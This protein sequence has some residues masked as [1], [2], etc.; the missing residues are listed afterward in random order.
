MPSYTPGVREFQAD[1]ETPGR[2]VLE[3]DTV[4]RPDAIVLNPRI[5][6]SVGPTA[7]GDISAGLQDRTWR[8]RAD[9]DNIYLARENDAGNGWDAEI[10][11]F[12]DYPQPPT[13][14]ALVD[15]ISLCFNEAAYPIVAMERDG[16]VWYVWRHPILLFYQLTKVGAGRT[17]KVALDRFLTVVTNCDIPSWVHLIYLRDAELIRLSEQSD[18]VGEEIGTLTGNADR[19]LEAFFPTDGRRLS[20][21]YS[22]HDTGTG[23][24]ELK[25]QD[26]L[27]YPTDLLKRPTINVGVAFSIPWYQGQQFFD[28][29]GSIITDGFGTDIRIDTLDDVDGIEIESDTD[30]FTEATG[31][32]EQ[33][34]DSIVD[35]PGGFNA[36]GGVTK[37]FVLTHGMGTMSPRAFRARTYRIIDGDRCYSQWEYFIV[38]HAAQNLSVVSAGVDGVLHQETFDVSSTDGTLYCIYLEA[39]AIYPDFT[40]VLLSSPQTLLCQ[41]V[42]D[43]NNIWRTPFSFSPRNKEHFT[44]TDVDGNVFDFDLFSKEF[45]SAVG[46]AP[47]LAPG[48]IVGSNQNPWTFPAVPPGLGSDVYFPGWEDEGVSEEEDPLF[49]LPLPIVQEGSYQDGGT[50]IVSIAADPSH[51]EQ[52]FGGAEVDVEIGGAADLDSTLILLLRRTEVYGVILFDQ[53]DLPLIESPCFFVPI[54]CITVDP[55]TPTDLISAE[56]DYACAFAPVRIVPGDECIPEGILD[57]D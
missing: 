1:F 35:F 22:D 43:V 51:V 23:R 24:W 50:E 6:H 55:V 13:E 34:Y 9:D 56:V 3:I 7:L 2:V 39:G 20:I 30:D 21:V 4:H 38:G 12:A 26:T 48:A 45:T 17:P 52:I 41:Q 14:L 18:F 46:S 11:L 28:P 33:V 16:E 31:W 19:Y 37:G 40:E 53:I 36:G 54:D 27:P 15:E 5:A 49:V 42:L 57:S 29:S 10:I 8:V 32:N 44:F 25:R 47:I